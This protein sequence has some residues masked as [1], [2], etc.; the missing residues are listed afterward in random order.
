M[1]ISEIFFSLQGEGLE[2][3]LPT[4]FVR[5]FACDLRCNWCDTMYAVEGRDFREHPVSEVLSEI[6]KYECKRV[7]ITGGEPLIQIKEV[8]EL[9]N[10]LIND[11]YKILLETSGHK[12]PPPILWAENS[13]ISMDCKC[14]SS[15]MQH[16]MDFDLFVKLRAKD[17]L[18]FVIQD[19]ID[20]KYAR[21]ILNSYNIKAN[22]IFQPTHGSDL[23]WITKKVIDDKLEF[24]R[25]LPQLHKIIWGDKRGV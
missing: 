16:K 15:S 11:N 18:K 5:L 21:G 19:E 12:M 17:Q 8:E 13:T 3:G 22:I 24:V 14:P 2:I 9:S 25:V 10:H 1:K 20:Y 4:V 7:C 23:G 6:E